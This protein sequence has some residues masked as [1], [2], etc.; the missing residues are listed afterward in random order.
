LKRG[1]LRLRWSKKK[2]KTDEQLRLRPQV[3]KTKLRKGD[4]LTSQKKR[5]G[6][7]GENT[8]ANLGVRR[9]I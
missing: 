8:K 7:G 3:G 5:V 2:K 1:S 4:T 9:E 6:K